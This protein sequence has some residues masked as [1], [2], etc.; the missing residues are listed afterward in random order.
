MEDLPGGSLAELLSRDPQAA[1][2]EMER[3][4][5]LLATLHA[6][7]GPRFGKAALVDGG[8]SSHDGSCARRVTDGAL[9][10]IEAVAARDPRIGAVREDLADRVRELADEVRPRPRHA[11]IHGELGPDHILLTPDGHPAL[12]DIEGLLYADLEH[13]HVFLRLRFGR[14]YDALHVP[15]LDDHRLR[16]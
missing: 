7:N 3:L 10:A 1:P 5:D 16:L 6:V 8:G 13:E 12:I 14:H 2:R 9:R 11:L 4:A 15:G